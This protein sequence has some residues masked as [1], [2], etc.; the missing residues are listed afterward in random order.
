VNRNWGPP[1]R[2][3]HERHN[4]SDFELRTQDKLEAEAD[5][6]PESSVDQVRD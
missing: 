1:E 6:Y 4:A 5:S 3:L 2:Q